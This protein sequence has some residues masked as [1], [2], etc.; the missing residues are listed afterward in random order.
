MLIFL[1]NIIDQAPELI[2]GTCTIDIVAHCCPF[3]GGNG[4]DSLHS[5]R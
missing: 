1:W 3:L 4:E 5:H 2:P